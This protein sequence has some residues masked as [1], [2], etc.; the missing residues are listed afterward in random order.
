MTKIIPHQNLF[1]NIKTLI[2]EAKKQVV[3][4]INTTMLITY[5]EI[6]RTIVEYEQKGRQRA[7]YAKETL[8]ILS[9]ALTN[10]FGKGYSV[11]NL[12][13]MRKFFITYAKSETL[14][15]ISQK[16]PGLSIYE[17]LSR[18]SQIPFLLSWSHYVQ[19]LKIGDD[20]ERGFYEIEANKNNW[21]VRELQRQF[22][23]ALYERLAL[24]R[25]KK[26]IRQLAKKGQLIEKPTD[27]L[28]SHYVLEFLDLK[29]DNRYTETELETE[30]IN[31]LEH[32]MLELGKGFLFEGRQRRFTFEGDSFFVDL[33]FYNRL[34]KCFV[35]IDLKIGKLAHQDIGQMQMYV[36]Y[37]D[38]IMKTEEEN[39]TIGIVLCREE[40]KTVVEFTLPRDNNQIFT[41]EYK[42][43]LPSKEEL[44]KQL[45]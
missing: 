8:K 42:H 18:K 25:D 22:N 15:R 32:F 38:R 5:F 43:Y 13:L 11:D 29:E 12:Q 41:K 2:E 26:G 40:N 7:E 19:L 30:I 1:R 14:S 33:V 27:A 35:I 3:R 10:E 36:N 37:Y 21:S 44:K 45:R 16:S 17:T 28:K 31:K 6:G 9:M 23:S 4:N 34:L 24:N 20:R 39:P